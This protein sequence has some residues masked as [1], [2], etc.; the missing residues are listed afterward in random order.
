MEKLLLFLPL[1]SVSLAAKIHN[2]YG[3]WQQ[4]AYHSNT[5]QEILCAEITFEKDDMNTKCRCDNGEE[6]VRVKFH[7]LVTAAN[8]NRTVSGDFIMLTA[9]TPDEIY[10]KMNIS[11]GCYQ[12]KFSYMM[13]ARS[14]NPN[15]LVMT[16]IPIFR[17]AV[18][19]NLVIVMA[20]EVPTLTELDDTLQ[21]IAELKNK[22]IVQKC[23]KDIK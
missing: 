10:H 5:Q 16:V 19:A 4:V 20:K 12:R 13:L 11:C 23:Y 17:N 8:K 14:V 3:T 1:L 22:T 7:G 2:F 21:G 9:N 18:N 15:Y 6:I